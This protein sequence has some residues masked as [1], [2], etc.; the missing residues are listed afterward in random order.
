MH[1][2]PTVYAG[3]RYRSRL[4]A[5]WAAFFDL[6][7]WHFEYEPCDFKGWIPDFVLFGKKPV[8]VEVKP[9]YDF[10]ENIAAEIDKSGCEDEAL[11]VG[12]TVPL[13]IREPDEAGQVV[14]TGPWLGWLREDYGPYGYGWDWGE[15]TPGIWSGTKSSLGFCHRTG[16]WVDR[17]SGVYNG[18][19]F[20]TDVQDVINHKWAAAKNLTQWRPNHV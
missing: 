14:T 6:A 1:A 15:A 17:I 11:I 5:R 2:I 8:Y 12:L 19:D 13:F 16:S 20:R 4:E 3:T 7:G 10:P 18:D 9:V